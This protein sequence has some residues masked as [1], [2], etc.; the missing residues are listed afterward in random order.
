VLI[1]DIKNNARSYKME[2]DSAMHENTKFLFKSKWD[3]PKA[4]GK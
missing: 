4:A 1:Y 3:T 2:I